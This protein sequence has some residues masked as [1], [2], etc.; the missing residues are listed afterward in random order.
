MSIFDCCERKD[1]TK[2]IHTCS[3]PSAIAGCVSEEINPTLCGFSEFAGYESS[4][5]KKYR[6]RTNT[7]SGQTIRITT[8]TG[9][10][11]ATTNIVIGGTRTYDDS[12]VVSGNYT[13]T[14]SYTSTEDGLLCSSTSTTYNTEE[15]ESTTSVIVG[16][17]E[18][19]TTQF[20]CTNPTSTVSATSYQK[21][22]GCGTN[23]TGSWLVQ[24]GTEDTE[25]QAIARETT[26]VAGTSCSSLWQIRSTGFDWTIRTSEYTIECSNLI[27]NLEYEV[28]PL[29]RKRTAVIDSEGAWED[30]TV[31]PVIFT[32]TSDTE[33]FAPVALG[34]IQGYE[35]QITGVSIERPA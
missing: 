32:A 15:V 22:G 5:P 25:E 8:A 27:T 13:F 26:P 7:G 10:T 31:T 28:S 9:E 16:T 35:Y 17:T 30:V 11:Y 3:C 34:H 20:V 12:C 6:S 18:T 21:G 29:I 33:T 14:K 4:P 19:C 23:R 1:E 2:Y 24:L